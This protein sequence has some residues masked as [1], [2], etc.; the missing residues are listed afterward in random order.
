MKNLGLG[1][2]FCIA[3]LTTQAQLNESYSPKSTLNLGLNIP[4]EDDEDERGFTY[5]VDLGVYLASKKTANI[6]NGAGGVE[7][8]TQTVWQSISERLTSLPNATSTITEIINA[9]LPQYNGTVTGYSFPIDHLPIDLNYSPRLYFGIGATYHFNKYWG[10]NIKSSLANLKTTGVYTM[11][12]QGPLPPQNASEVIEIFDVT[13]EERRVHFDL[14]FRNTSYNDFGFKWFWGGGASLVG[15]QIESN[16]AWIGQRQFPLL[17][18]NSPNINQNPQAA[19]TLQTTF[20]LGFF[21]TTGWEMEYDEK[22][23]VAIGF[24]LS[25]DPIELGGTEQ[26]VYNKRI[27]FSFGI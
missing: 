15:A 27:Y 3:T 14:G 19:E 18:T 1:I 4:A 20:N 11:R 17:L 8:N 23:D 24:V 16:T 26:T 22:F 6:Y 5:A 13:G 25:R 21:A 12:L 10:L 2:L 7:I 9:E